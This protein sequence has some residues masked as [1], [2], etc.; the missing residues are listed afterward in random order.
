MDVQAATVTPAPTVTV[1]VGAP[2]AAA[3]AA[4]TVFPSTAG[5]AAAPVAPVASAAPSVGPPPA[6]NPGLALLPSGSSKGGSATGADQSFSSS[7]ADLYNVPKATTQVSFRVAP[8]S[9]EIVTVVS[10]TATGKVLAQFPSETLI[11]LAQ[12]F[13]KLD[14]SVVDQKV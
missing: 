6:A 7:V 4:W 8:G 5:R 12:F 11:A 14:G 9:N 2:S 3:N 13:Q 10:D 1:S